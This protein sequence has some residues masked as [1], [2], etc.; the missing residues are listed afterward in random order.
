VARLTAARSTPMIKVTVTRVDAIVGTRNASGA[1]PMRRHF[2]F[3][4]DWK[5]TVDGPRAP[6]SAWQCAPSFIAP[7][8]QMRHITVR[9]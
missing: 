7:H 6:A 4:P 5:S 8:P 2:R 3:V 9:V 1:R